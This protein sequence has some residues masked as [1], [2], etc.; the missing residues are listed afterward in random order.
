MEVFIE[1]LVKRK[2]G[3]SEYLQMACIAFFGVSATILIFSYLMKLAPQFGSLVTL[4]AFAG[5]YFLYIWI[6][7]YNVEYEYAL[8]NNEIDVD[9]IVN[10]RKRRRMTTVNIKSVEAFGTKGENKE[11]EKYFQNAGITKVYACAD[12]RDG[13]VF[14][15]VYTENDK[16]KML[17]FNPNEKMTEIIKVV[18][19]RRVMV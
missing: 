12:K 11:F 13:N 6:T 2:K 16:K 3:I 5:I 15:V 19:S 17:L 4:A 10:V 7:Q 8:V 9:K 14:F 1:Y 18:A